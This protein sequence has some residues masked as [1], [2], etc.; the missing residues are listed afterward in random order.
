MIAVHALL[1]DL[2]GTLVDTRDANYLAYAAA[3]AEFGVT[4]DRAS[5]ERAAE[6]RNWRQFLPTMLPEGDAADAAAVAARKA[7]L[8]P[9]M[10][11]GTALNEPLAALLCAMQ[12]HC[13]TALVTTASATNAHA[14]LAHHNIGGLFDEIITGNDVTV[15]K[16]D[17][18]AYALAGARLGVLPAECVA[19]EDSDIGV[20]A[21]TRFGARC[22]RVTFPLSL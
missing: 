10:V 3:L 4:I 2:D 14:V 21:A 11:S 19:F 7:V 17:P 5:F 18:E 8:Y 16:P 12:T 15:H 1:V 22:V 6:G 9:A 20:A 13:K